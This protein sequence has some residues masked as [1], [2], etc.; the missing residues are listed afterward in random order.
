MAEVE[1]AALDASGIDK[2]FGATRVLHDVTVRVAPGEVRALL[3]EN[4]AGKSTLIKIIAGVLQPDRGRI[5]VGTAGG[6]FHDPHDAER[7][8]VATQHQE[9]AV[10][11]GCL[12]AALMGGVAAGAA[13]DLESWAADVVTVARTFTP[14]PA[15]ADRFDALHAVYR[16]TYTALETRFTDLAAFSPPRCE[17][18]MTHT[19]PRN[20]GVEFSATM[21]RIRGQLRPRTAFGHEGRLSTRRTRWPSTCCSS[22][23]EGRRRLPMMSRWTSG[24]PRRSRRTSG[25]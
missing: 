21:S 13:T 23:T 2:S 25:S 24:S 8:G 3:G 17:P 10:I 18:E 7:H 9:L 14:D 4:G 20:A 12:G 5:V 15:A 16:D 1:A 11:P 19:A 6:P 22:T